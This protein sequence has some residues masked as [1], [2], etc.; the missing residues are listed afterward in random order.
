L[1]D[2]AAIPAADPSG[3]QMADDQPDIRGHAMTRSNH[4]G[5]LALTPLPVRSRFEDRPPTRTVGSR[6]W[7]R[8]G[9]HLSTWRRDERS[10][11]ELMNLSDRILQDI[12][13]SRG[14][15][16]PELSQPIWLP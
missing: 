13:L 16:K 15:A 2:F 4:V 10:R 7:G 5:I 9:H 6:L 8:L 14:E 1:V 11:R 12:G 3:R